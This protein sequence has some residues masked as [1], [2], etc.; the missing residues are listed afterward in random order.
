MNWLLEPFRFEFMQKALLGCLLIGFTNGYLSAFIVLRRYALLADALSHSLL[1]GVALGVIFWG[2][3]P[4]GLFAGALL[5]ALLVV[6]GG[7]M[8]SSSSRLKDDTSIGALYIISFALG[9]ILLNYSSARVD[10][11]HFLFGN[12]LGLSN[13][14]I[15]LTYGLSALILIVLS[16]VHRHLLLALFDSTVA[17]SLGIRVA[18]FDYLLIALMVTA[19]ISSLQAVGVVLSLGLLILPAATMYLLSDSF[20]LMV[21][22]GATLGAGGAVAGLLLSYWA[23]LPSGPSIVLVLGLVFV[24]AYLFGPRYGIIARR[25]RKRH[26]HEESLERWNHPD[27]SH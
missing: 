7:K 4:M 14:D 12:V 10:L 13:M 19:M 22:G 20:A 17:L 2:L 27:H 9:V 25:L 18:R 11:S 26:L 23:D 16:I 24:L 15:W 21:W 3:Q 1:P 6:L 8:I 5:A